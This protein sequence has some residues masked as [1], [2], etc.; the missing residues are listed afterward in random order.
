MASLQ[1]SLLLFCCLGGGREPRPFVAVPK[2]HASPPFLAFTF[3]ACRPAISSSKW[4]V[5]SNLHFNVHFYLGWW[6][7]LSHCFPW[8][9]QYCKHLLAGAICI[10][11][12]L[13]WLIC[14][15][16]CFS[17]FSRTYRN[18][19]YIFW[20]LLFVSEA[21]LTSWVDMRNPWT[22]L[23]PPGCSLGAA[24]AQT[25]LCTAVLVLLGLATG[26]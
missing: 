22:N 24:L 13:S 18:D 5:V 7:H 25:V 16:W 26:G 17:C 15:F 6:Y 3:F 19:P 11:L 4:P 23:P 8:S 12:L 14:L 20:L 2:I 1:L 10:D 21:A 9:H